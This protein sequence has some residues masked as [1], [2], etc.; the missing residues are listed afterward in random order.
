MRLLHLITFTSLMYGPVAP[1][2]AQANEGA[3]AP[4]IYHSLVYHSKAKKVLLFGG[5]SRHGWGPDRSEVWQYD[6]SNQTWTNLGNYAAISAD[7]VNAHSPAYDI[8]SD[9]IIVFNSIGETWAFDL[10]KNS[11]ENRR[12]TS[13]PSPRCGQSMVYDV[14]SDRMV[15]F[16]GFGCTSIEDPILN[17]TWTYDIN[18]NN[19][20]K[21]EPAQNPPPRMYATM[22]YNTNASESIVWGG[23][24]IES[25]DDP[26]FWTYDFSNN[27]W[28]KIEGTGGPESTYAYPDMIYHPKRNELIL[29]GGG[30]LTEAFSGTLT[31]ALWKFDLNERKWH[32]LSSQNGP[33]PVYL[34]AMLLLEDQDQIMLFGGEVTKMYSD[35][36]L[37][38]TWNLDL[39][40]YQ[41]NKN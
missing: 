39:L 24:L 26:F 34:H 4:M 29:F 30:N 11:W 41:W 14:A 16:G 36:L 6:P 19:W 22:V 37:Q 35:T 38:G 7:T 2:L 13:A 40:S 32:K 10:T 18:A 21:M 20:E 9:R 1:S 3:P 31:Q 27:T 8:E 5:N 12:P 28:T 17:D 15:L 23:R 25:L 33:P